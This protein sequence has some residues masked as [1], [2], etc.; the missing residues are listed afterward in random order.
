MTYLMIFSL[1]GKD[2]ICCHSSVFLI[3]PTPI[4]DNS[5]GVDLKILIFWFAHP[6]NV[7]SLLSVLRA[8]RLPI[9]TSIIHYYVFKHQSLQFC[10]MCQCTIGTKVMK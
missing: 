6:I 8:P 4:H 5:L 9:N 10:N 7:Y 1:E 2:K 3:T